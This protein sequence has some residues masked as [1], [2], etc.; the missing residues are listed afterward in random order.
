[1]RRIIPIFAL[2]ALITL[3]SC[4]W[5]ELKPGA[6]SVQLLPENRVGDC[7]SLSTVKVSVLEKVG[8]LERH[9][10]EVAADLADL[11]RNH[12]IEAGGDTIAALGPITNGTQEFGVYQCGKAAETSAD[13]EVE[14]SPY[15]VD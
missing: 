8:I 1:M 12:A 14:T 5:V 11:A 10:D 6:A 13:S 9:D 3:V 4:T 15:P 7:K 2:P